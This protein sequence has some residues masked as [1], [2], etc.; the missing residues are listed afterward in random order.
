METLLYSIAAISTEM[1]ASSP[2]GKTTL[3]D[4]LLKCKKNKQQKDRFLLTIEL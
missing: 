4:V 3:K 1:T 2:Q